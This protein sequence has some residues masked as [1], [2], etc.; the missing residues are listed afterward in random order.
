MCARRHHKPLG[1]C[2]VSY[3]SGTPEYRSFLIS[4]INLW[5]SIARIAPRGSLMAKA[6]YTHWF[7][8]RRKLAIELHST[9]NTA[10]T[11]YQEAA[12]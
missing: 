1:D 10:M 3:D 9:T 6:A 4:Q 7:D 8:A 5:A 2:R 12:S 11:I